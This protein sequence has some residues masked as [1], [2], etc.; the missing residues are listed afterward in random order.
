VA[1]DTTP[2]GYPSFAHRTAPH[3]GTR[4]RLTTLSAYALLKPP[5]VHEER[6]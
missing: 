3:T 1:L 2:N 5:N 6:T 4:V